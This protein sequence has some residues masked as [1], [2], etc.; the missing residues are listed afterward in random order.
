MHPHRTH[1]YT[2]AGKKAT[3]DRL[4]DSHQHTYPL[5]CWLMSSGTLI[6]THTLT[7]CCLRPTAGWCCQVTWQSQTHLPIAVLTNIVRYPD[8][9]EHIYPLLTDVDRYPDSH[10]HT[11]PL[12]ADVVRYPDSHKHTYTLTHCCVW[13]IAGWCR[14]VP[15]WPGLLRCFFLHALRQQAQGCGWLNMQ[16]SCPHTQIAEACRVVLEGRVWVCGWQ[17]KKVKSK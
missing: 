3:I 4:S 11:Y 1:L 2:L 12:L 13:P 9:H 14:Q 7:C 6:V 8:S 10:K 15:S 5:L 17:E 16:C